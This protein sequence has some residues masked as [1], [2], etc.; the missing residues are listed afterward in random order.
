[1]R[2]CLPGAPR[3]GAF[4]LIELVLVVA[5][6]LVIIAIAVPRLPPA[7]LGKADAYGTARMIASDIRLARRLAITNASTNSTG[8]ALILTPSSPYR[9]YKIVD[10]STG[11]TVGEV[12]NIPAGVMCTGDSQFP[13]GPLGNITV[14]SPPQLIFSRGGYQCTLSVT[15]ATGRVVITK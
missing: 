1:M 7:V 12:K 11:G 10:S 6:V 13:F 15:V 9:N 5:I 14:G 4:S 2:G 3:R 8:Y